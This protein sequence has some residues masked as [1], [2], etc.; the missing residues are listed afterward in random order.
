MQIERNNVLLHPYIYCIVG[1]R[2]SIEDMLNIGE[3]EL[4]RTQAMTTI[5]ENRNRAAPKRREMTS[6]AEQESEIAR[7]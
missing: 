6:I 5:E 7:R 4:R 3:V 1:S 2:Y